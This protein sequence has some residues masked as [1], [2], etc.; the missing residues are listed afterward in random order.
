MLSAGTD[1]AMLTELID[2]LA[3]K[4]VGVRKPA[5]KEEE[6]VGGETGGG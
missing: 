4:P 3:G 2:G 6:Y 5:A 1:G